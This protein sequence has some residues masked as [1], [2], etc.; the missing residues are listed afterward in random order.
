MKSLNLHRC[1]SN[2]KSRIGLSFNVPKEENVEVKILAVNAES[3][4]YVIESKVENKQ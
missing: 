3:W 4:L 2:Q 1:C